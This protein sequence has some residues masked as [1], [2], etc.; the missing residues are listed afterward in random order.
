LVSFYVV[1][2][3][4]VSLSLHCIILTVSMHVCCVIFNKVSVS[5]SVTIHCAHNFSFIF[6][7]LH[8]LAKF[9]LC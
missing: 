7:E 3:F 5:V 6:D 8:F 1:T 9:L 4:Y 2:F